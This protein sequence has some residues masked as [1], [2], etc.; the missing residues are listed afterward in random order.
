MS[1]G[2]SILVAPTASPAPR[3]VDQHLGPAGE[4]VGGR[5]RPLAVDQ[6]DP[7][8]GAVVAQLGH[9]QGALLQQAQVVLASHQ[10]YFPL[11][12]N[13]WKYSKRSSSPVYTATRLLLVRVVVPHSCFNRPRLVC[14]RGVK[15]GS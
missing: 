6:E 14:L 13:L 12:T 2:R 4:A 15:S 5:E 10:R 9:V 1:S 11:V 3:G 7:P 8:A